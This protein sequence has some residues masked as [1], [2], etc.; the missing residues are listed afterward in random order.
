[1]GIVRLF[2]VAVF[3]I[4]IAGCT[5]SKWTIIEEQAID[6]TE[7][8]ET[9]SENQK[10]LLEERPTIERPVL[11]LVPYHIVQREFAERIKVQRMVQQ[12]KPK[13]GF[14]L[15][16][17]AGSAFSFVAANSDYVLPSA[18]TT[19]RVALNTTGVMLAFLATTNLEETGD[20]IMTDEIRYLRQ[21][22]FETK[23]DTLAIDDPGEYTGSVVISFQNEEIFNESSIPLSSG[24]VEINLGS[25]AS[26]VADRIDSES[27]FLVSTTYN[28]IRSVFTIQATEFLESYFVIEEPV[29]PVRSSA[30]VN[31]DNVIAEL[32]EG[33]ALK[34]TDRRSDQWIGIEYGSVDAFVQKSDGHVEW[35]STAEDG[36]ALL[37]ELADIPFGE[38]DVENSI[39]VLKSRNPADRAL[40]LSGNQ[41]NQLSTRQFS[42][43]DERLFRHYMRTA[44]RMN[45]D[46]ILTID[47][48]DF[49]DWLPDLEFCR[50]MDGGSLVIFLTGYAQLITSNGE[51]KLALLKV[52]EKGDK[53][54]LLLPELF[55]ELSACNSQK[56]FLFADLEYVEAVQDGQILSVR[57]ENGAKQ[58]QLANNLLQNF[59]NSFILFG[60]RIGQRSSLYSGSEENDKRH[61]VFPY[62]WAEA[63]K[64]RKTQMS[65]LVRHLE[66]NVDYTSRRLHDRPQEVQGFGNFMLNL[67]E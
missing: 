38:I 58:Q 21:T 29:I 33:S 5:T 61:H 60:N 35:R 25:L 39:P 57:K 26:N 13:W 30:S 43:R 23:T 34:I 50:E 48:P 66:N 49:S 44:L 4:G 19:Q 24:S 2:F 16:T 59:P 28:D 36:P 10:L 55:E 41:G 27:E 20:P 14:A 9:I 46:Q 62:Y 52:D 15:L 18:T 17:L 63:L 51:E 47:Q 8:P 53:Q 31:Q 45:D 64:Q 37:V 12:Y 54:H 56:I 42:N 32:G 22:G 7:T 1:M 67:A 11:K 6:S 3:L 40:V 65:E